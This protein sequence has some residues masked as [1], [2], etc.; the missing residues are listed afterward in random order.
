MA[1]IKRPTVTSVGENM[2]QEFSHT[3]TGNVQRYKEFQNRLAVCNKRKRTYIFPSH[4]ILSILP[5]KRHKKGA[6]RCKTETQSQKHCNREKQNKIKPN[7][8][9]QSCNR[10]FT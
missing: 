4:S 2:N 6:V 7:H 1:K 9:K 10:V 3:A 8:T 5:K